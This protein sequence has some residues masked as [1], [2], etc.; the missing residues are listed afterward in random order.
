MKKEKFLTLSP[1]AKIVW[2]RLDAATRESICRDNPFHLDRNV[3]IRTLRARGVEI[4]VLCEV[5]GM[6]HASICKILSKKIGIDN[7]SR[8]L[9]QDFDALKAAL[10]DYQHSVLMIL[11]RDYKKGG[12]QKNLTEKKGSDDNNR[13]TNK[14]NVGSCAASGHE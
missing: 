14:S 6:C 5:T 10:D 7:F 11:E 4:N 8:K 13:K 9:E 2:N 12:K 1:K 3:S